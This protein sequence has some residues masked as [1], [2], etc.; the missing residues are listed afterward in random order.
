MTKENF[1]QANERGLT[2]RLK[3]KSRRRREDISRLASAAAAT[4][5]RRNDI[6]PKIELVD[7]ALDELQLPLRKVRNLDPAHV[8]EVAGS[9]S[10][11]GFCDPI[12]IGKRNLVLDGVVRIQ[13]L[14]QLGVSH[15]ACIHMDHLSEIEQRAL[16][17]S[18]N[19]LGEKGEWNL[20]ALS[21]P[22]WLM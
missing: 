9:I 6:R 5:P 20:G 19:R 17:L 7:I 1:T 21:S 12:L 16:R 13:A 8:R 3:G 2:E 11:L 4:C 14:R 10:A 22:K 15:A 18:V